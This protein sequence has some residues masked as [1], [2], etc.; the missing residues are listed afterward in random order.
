MGVVVV[1]GTSSGIGLVLAQKLVADETG[2]LTTLVTLNKTAESALASQRALRAHLPTR[3]ALDSRVVD[4][5]SLRQLVDQANALRE[6]YPE[7]D[8]LVLNAGIMFAPFVTIEGIETQRCPI[9]RHPLI[10]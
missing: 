8:V 10:Y 5:R 3:V 4:L 6:R 7:I 9:F 1:T 2:R